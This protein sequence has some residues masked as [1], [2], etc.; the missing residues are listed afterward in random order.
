[1]NKHPGE[2]PLE[3]EKRMLE[4]QI[5]HLE[6]RLDQQHAIAESKESS[7]KAVKQAKALAFTIK[8]QL[9]QAVNRMTEIE[10]ELVRLAAHR[11]WI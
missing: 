4:R 6:E 10:M 5:A 11:P 1:M 7:R 2:E 8:E 3:A 9:G